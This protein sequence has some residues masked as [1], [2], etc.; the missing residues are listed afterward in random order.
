MSLALPISQ[1][2]ELPM[3]LV[4]LTSPYPKISS[5]QNINLYTILPS[6]IEVE[7]SDCV[8][9]LFASEVY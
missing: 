8:S 9:L 3:L 2:K 7:N 5:L 1:P 6:T 4:V